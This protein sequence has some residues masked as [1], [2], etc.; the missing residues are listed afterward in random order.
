MGEYGG[1]LGI[2]LG[3]EG[4]RGRGCGFIE[5][6]WW[7]IILEGKYIFEFINQRGMGGECW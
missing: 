5:F 2:D 1:G 6:G 7:G 4:G 3:E